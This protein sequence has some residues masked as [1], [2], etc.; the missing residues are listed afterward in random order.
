[1]TDEELIL[2]SQKGNEQA[3]NELLTRYK[4]LV[5]SICKNQRSCKKFKFFHFCKG[6]KN[7]RKMKMRKAPCKQVKNYVV[8]HKNLIHIFDPDMKYNQ[9]YNRNFRPAE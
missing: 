9:L 3:T 1:M 8:I 2:D 5:K 6:K 4:G 7:C